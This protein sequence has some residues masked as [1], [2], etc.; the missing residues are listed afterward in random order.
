MSKEYVIDGQY[1]SFT[2]VVERDDNLPNGPNVF[3]ETFVP[4]VLLKSYDKEYGEDTLVE[5]AIGKE[6]N[7]AGIEVTWNDGPSSGARIP[8][9]EAIKFF[10]DAIKMLKSDAN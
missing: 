6:R 3:D 5:I 2:N 4:Y 1:G 9:E 8:T 10:E 7:F